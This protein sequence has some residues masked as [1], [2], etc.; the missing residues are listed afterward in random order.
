MDPNVRPPAPLKKFAFTI[1]LSL[2]SCTIL[3]AT[4]NPSSQETQVSQD[5]QGSQDTRA[6]A[7]AQQPKVYSAQE[8]EELKK[9]GWVRSKYYAAS[10]QSQLNQAA[11]AET[12]RPKLDEFREVIAPI[13]QSTCVDCHGESE[14][15]G[16]IR[17]DTLD[18]NLHAGKD[19]DWWNE[20]YAVVS[21][22][23]MPPADS[24]ELT[25]ADRKKVVEWLS[26][27]LQSASIV[28]R[29]SS[30]HS[31]FR[32]M[33]RYETNYA[34]Q[35]LLGLPWNFANDLPPD[36]HSDES[37]QNSSELLHMSVS[38]FET[39]HRLARAAISRAIVRGEQ[40]KTL[41][42]GI[43][44]KDASRLEWP[45]QE[46]QIAEAKKKFESEPEK[47]K[48]E[49]AR[50]QESFL[51]EHSR[52]YYRDLTSG[53]TALV[54]WEYDGAKHA[55]SPAA[56]P[57]AIPDSVDHVAILPAGQSINIELGNQIP[58]EGTLRVR[59][60]ASKTK[61]VQDRS[62]SLQLYF[63]WQAS[64]EGRALIRVSQ[65]DTPVTAEPER[66]SSTSGIFHLVKST[67]ATRC[68]PH[69]PWVRFRVHRSTFGW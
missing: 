5:A 20:I 8:L 51:K 56:E 53:K 44:M 39:Y 24:N 34:L 58:D 30:S 32:R 59:V 22:G 12:P 50:I 54:T 11:L 64:N 61:S 68:E 52:A 31:T 46:K 21:K 41:H 65:T 26:T 63:G 43:T 29:Q 9:I 27:E 18:P 62:P 7:K 67:L 47:L 42:W 23:E 40:P 2:L 36:A 37:F 6:E 55:M 49:L 4:D 60:R 15:E 19:V 3:Q 57:I 13:L 14:Q 16:N 66:V 35:D 1:L 17:I 45:K 10:Q 28:R 69:R 33:T 48:E 25:E 38:Q